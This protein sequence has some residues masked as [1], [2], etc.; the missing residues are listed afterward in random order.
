MVLLEAAPAARARHCDSTI[1][2][3]RC[4]AEYLQLFGECGLKV[5]AVTGV[6]P[7][8]FRYRLLPHLRRLPRA[9]AIATTTAVS[10][11]SL[12]MDSLLGRYA[13]DRSWHAVFVL[14]RD[15]DEGRAHA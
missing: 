4:R 6:D 9:L 13:V 7:T 1:F 12:P 15:C 2:R 14:D 3:A 8:P 10:L 5:R 11:A